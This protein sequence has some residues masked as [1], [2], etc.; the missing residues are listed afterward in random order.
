MNL[1]N[2]LAVSDTGQMIRDSLIES[3]ISFISTIR[4]Y[5]S[6]YLGQM[7]NNERGVLKSFLKRHIVPKGILLFHSPYLVDDNRKLTLPLKMKVHD[8][9]D[10]FVCFSSCTG[11]CVERKNRC[12]RFVEWYLGKDENEGSEEFL[13]NA[14]NILIKERSKK[15]DERRRKYLRERKKE[16]RDKKEMMSSK[17]ESMNESLKIFCKQHSV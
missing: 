1:L 10:D 9:L 16:R 7:E 3:Q 14:R 8:G 4:F 11:A 2:G 17:I 5:E 15:V 12:N 6:I 13:E